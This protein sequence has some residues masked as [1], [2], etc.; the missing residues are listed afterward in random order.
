MRM[1]LRFSIV[2]VAAA[3]KLMGKNAGDRLLSVCFDSL[4]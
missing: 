1:L 2:G 3:G 4:I